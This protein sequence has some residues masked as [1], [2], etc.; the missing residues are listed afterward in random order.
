M[1]LEF[2]E[3]QF[4]YLAFRHKPTLGTGGPASEEEPQVLSLES[5]PNKQSGLYTSG[6]NRSQGESVGR[7]VTSSGVYIMIKV[8]K[9]MK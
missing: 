4:P 1:G 9:W 5:K 3:P 2:K 6:K 8:Q 7:P